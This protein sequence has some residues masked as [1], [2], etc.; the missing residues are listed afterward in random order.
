MYY[1]S[2]RDRIWEKITKNIQAYG[3]A[4]PGVCDDD[5]YG[6]GRWCA[7]GWWRGGQL[8]AITCDCA[9]HAS[10][11]RRHVRHYV[12]PRQLQADPELARREL[13]P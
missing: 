2:R 6:N 1:Q 9:P 7:L 11:R 12:L 4:W 3:Y 10:G 5:G 13:A 8:R